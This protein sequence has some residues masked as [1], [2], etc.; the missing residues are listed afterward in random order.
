MTMRIRYDDPTNNNE[1]YW[2]GDIYLDEL[3][4]DILVA[5]EQ[6]NVCVGDIKIQN[7]DGYYDEDEENE[8][9]REEFWSL[10]QLVEHID[11][12]GYDD[13]KDSLYLGE[14]FEDADDLVKKF[15]YS[16]KIKEYLINV[17]YNIKK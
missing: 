17:G 12:Y 7:L 15:K 5:V 10:R 13:K 2:N 3:L 9:D 4:K 1:E 8:D 6:K 14:T 16:P 11:E